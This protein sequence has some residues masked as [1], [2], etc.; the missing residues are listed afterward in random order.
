MKKIPFLSF[1]VLDYLSDLLGPQIIWKKTSYSR[2]IF[3]N[4]SFPSARR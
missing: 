2:I 3:L 4:F 1:P